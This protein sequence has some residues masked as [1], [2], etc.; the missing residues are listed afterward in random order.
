MSDPWHA[1][2]P[3]S[4]STK[5]QER[6]SQILDDLKR[7]L[8][9][10]DTSLDDGFRTK[11]SRSDESRSESLLSATL[12]LLAVRAGVWLG[13]LTLL[14]WDTGSVSEVSLGFSILVGSEEVN[15]LA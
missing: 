7:R 13:V 1:S 5:S 2:Q 15:S 6:G 8:V 9:K 10:A 11:Y 3:S 4:R 14:A 12:E